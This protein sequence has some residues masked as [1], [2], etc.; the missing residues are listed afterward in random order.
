VST[1]IGGFDSG[2]VQVSTGRSVK[3]TG[4]S[5]SS[6]QTS[7]ADSSLA[8]T[9]I[10]DSARTLAALDQLVQDL[11]AVDNARVEQVRSRLENGSYE[12]NPERIADKLLKAEQ[13]LDQLK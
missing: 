6:S 7:S 4:D 3:R 1:K 8:D 2:P 10:T 13:E 9:H 5:G 12:I 11:P